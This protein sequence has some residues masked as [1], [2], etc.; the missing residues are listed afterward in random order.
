[1]VLDTTTYHLSPISYELNRCAAPIDT[2]AWLVI[3]LPYFTG[4]RAHLISDRGLLTWP[5]PISQRDIL[6]MGRTTPFLPQFFSG[7]I[8]IFS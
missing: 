8:A 5:S 1:M 6:G 7:E 3:A 2:I 4:E